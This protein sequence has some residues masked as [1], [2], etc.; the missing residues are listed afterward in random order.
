MNALLGDLRYTL[1]SWAREPGFA[2][3]AMLTVALGVAANT[4]VFSIVNGVI[5][6]PLAYHEPERLYLLEQVILQWAHMYP[7]LSMNVRQFV[8]LKEDCRG[9]E[10]AAIVRASGMPMS[11][12]AETEFV[13]AVRSSAELFGVLGV[14]P[15]AGRL[16]R[17]DEEWA[18]AEQVTILT[19]SF[20]R[21]RFNADPGV[22]GRT[23]VLGGE[24]H[25]IVGVLPPSFR[26]FK[27]NQ[28]GMLALPESTDLFLPLNEA[29]EGQPVFGDF[30]FS[31]IVRLRPGVKAA[32]AEAEA[33]ARLAALGGGKYPETRARLT[34][35]REQVVGRSRT[36]L[37]MLMA[38]V[39]AVLLIGCA[40]L[41]NLLL[42]RITRRSKE[43]AIRA[44]LGASR[45]RLIRLTLTESLSLALA[46]GVLG[47]ALAWAGLRWLMRA[48]PVDLP[49]ADEVS[50]DLGALGFAVGTSLVTG[51]LLGILPAWR[52]SRS[53]PQEAMRAGGRTSSESGR[54]MRLKQLLVSFQTGLGVMLLVTAALLVTS[55]TRLTMV[56]KGFDVETVVGLELML[57]PS[58][59]PKFAQR[60][61]FKE[62]LIEAV[63][64]L[65][66]VV[67]AGVSNTL[68]LQGDVWLDAIGIEGTTVPLM[69]WPL[70]NYRPVNADYFR[71]LGIPLRKGRL[72]AEADR[73]L[74]PAIVTESTA[75]RLWPGQNPIG[76]RFRRADPSDAPYEII[77]V[78]GDIRGIRLEEAPGLMVYL[79]HWKRTQTRVTLLV[80][81]GIEAAALASAVR[82]AVRRID[83]DVALAEV[84]TMR[85]IVEES[86][87][88]R[89]F[90]TLLAVV[91]AA[92]ALVLAALGVY[93][94][95]SYS[96][97]CRIHEMGIRIALGAAPGQLYRMVL[98]QGMLPVAAGISAGLIGALAVG[99]ML[100]SLLFGV[101]PHDPLIITAVVTAL[102]AVA[103]A[104]CWLPARRAVRVDPGVALRSE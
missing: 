29:R 50:L 77:G 48:A 8:T 83:P 88:G 104:A 24:P 26:F 34:P 91:F 51:F 86:T 1:R 38:A 40:N 98:G 65:P 101:A 79:P 72:F 22:L 20:W 103:A 15:A 87:A 5:L 68:P 25:T 64:A 78:A 3:V 73:R 82:D 67:S 74:N 53:E 89:R 23:V 93:G 99:G 84:K 32:E 21:R 59:Y 70:A 66:G 69:E 33:T 39:A 56:D 81:T 18:G 100:R 35:L 47:V 85:R 28:L 36:A 94:V 17:R 10:S 54:A 11:G 44:A 30:N 41:A 58:K 102:S 14:R 9:V 61:R 97:T 63:P 4:A 6:R 52:A 62:Q 90:Q 80:R 57:P 95:V 7:A 92:A 49:R 60:L 37:L 71:T 13:R 76:K 43:T 55:F 16:F 96:V 75:R 27:K 42:V 46:G 2:A 12:G 45:S 19:D 31:M